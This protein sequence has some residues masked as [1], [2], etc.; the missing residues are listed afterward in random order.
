MVNSSCILD[1]VDTIS[2]IINV[3]LEGV[4]VK[5]DMNYSDKNTSEE[6]LRN[7]L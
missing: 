3:M 5:M 1:R 2:I 6:I 7:R 4:V